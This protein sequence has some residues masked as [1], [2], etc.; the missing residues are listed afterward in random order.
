SRAR[1]TAKAVS[2]PGSATTRTFCAMVPPSFPWY[3]PCDS[4]G[5]NQP[6][7]Y[8][9]NR[10]RGREKRRPPGAGSTRAEGLQHRP[11]P[12]RLDRGGGQGHPLRRRVHAPGGQQ[13]GGRVGPP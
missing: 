8:H 10:G 2:M 5:G 1:A 9:A 4:Q 12:P 11:R 13:G 6:V 3:V 7:L